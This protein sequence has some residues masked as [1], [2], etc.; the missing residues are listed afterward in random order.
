M[1]A[2]TPASLRRPD[3]ERAV[4]HLLQRAPGLGPARLRG[5]ATDISA[6]TSEGQEGRGLR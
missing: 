6:A 5:A 1:K 3:C 4:W 2:P